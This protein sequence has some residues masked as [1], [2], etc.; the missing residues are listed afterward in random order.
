MGVDS[1]NPSLVRQY[2]VENDYTL[3]K[4]DD[5][6]SGHVKL[7]CKALESSSNV[8]GV[9]SSV[10]YNG[11]DLTQTTYSEDATLTDEWYLYLFKDASFVAIPLSDWTDSGNPF[12]GP[13]ESIQGIGYSDCY[14]NY[15]NISNSMIKKEFVER[16][17]FSRIT[18]IRTHGLPN[19]IMLKGDML[20]RS[21]LLAMP[22]DTLQCSELI[23]YVACETAQGGKYA[24]NLVAATIDAGART[25]IGFEN[26]VAT[27]AATRWI[28]KFFEYYADYSMVDSKNIDDV[29]TDTDDYMQDDPQYEFTVN[30]ELITL[31]TFVIAGES[32][33]PN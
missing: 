16:M 10:S 27:G 6:A 2:S 18:V 19:L 17:Q 7:I 30:G 12:T 1:S 5:T 13:I 11:L 31:R 28:S 4:F 32:E 26:S 8:L 9:S 33:F 23:V 20:N 15:S 14:D 29:L 25:V 22:A 24:E 21:D 3:W